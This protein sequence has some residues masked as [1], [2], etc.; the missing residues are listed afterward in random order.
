MMKD[1]NITC[2]YC[3]TKLE[4]KKALYMTQDRQE[5][6]QEDYTDSLTSIVAFDY[7]GREKARYDFCNDCYAAFLA[8]MD[9]KAKAFGNP[10]SED[11]ANEIKALKEEQMA[12]RQKD[13]GTPV[14]PKQI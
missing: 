3:D 11:K 12:N 4:A 5:R 6:V 2:D 9:D 14:P 13:L 8:D 1:V 7:K 10:T